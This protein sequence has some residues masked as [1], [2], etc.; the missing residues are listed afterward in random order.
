MQDADHNQKSIPQVEDKRMKIVGL[1]SKNAHL[2]FLGGIA[3]LMTIIIALPGKNPPKERPASSSTANGVSTDPNQARI[4]EY[5]ARI[6]QEAR[7]LSL[8]EAQLAQTK[9][10]LS[11]PETGAEIQ[12]RPTGDIGQI[13]TRT[14]DWAPERVA[15][16]SSDQE[17]REAMA[18]YAS[19]IALSYRQ[20]AGTPTPAHVAPIEPGETP[21]GTVTRPVTEPAVSPRFPAHG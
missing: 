14:G 16:G 20:L 9:Q 17:K 19:N 2:K 13:Y 4:E 7:K 10:A 6:D 1:L 15:H 5:R 12:R 8:E 3:L 11:A 21:R 18:P